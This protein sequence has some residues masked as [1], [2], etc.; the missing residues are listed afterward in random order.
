MVVVTGHFISHHRHQC[1]SHPIPIYGSMQIN[2]RPH[3]QFCYKLMLPL[4]VA[5]KSTHILMSSC[6]LAP[7]VV[8]VA[9]EYFRWNEQADLAKDLSPP[10]AGDGKRKQERGRNAKATA[11]PD[12]IVT[13]P[14]WQA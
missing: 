6:C 14:D 1:S 7:V 11:S 5:C 12:L 9:A 2:T 3:V 13:S 8:V 10:E 4:A